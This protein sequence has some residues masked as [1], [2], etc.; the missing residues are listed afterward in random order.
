MRSFVLQPWTTVRGTAGSPGVTSVTQDESDYLDLSEYADA[1]FWVDIAGLTQPAGGV[2]TLNLESSPSRDESSFQPIAPAITLALP[3]AAGAVAPTLVKTIRTPSTVALSRWTRWRINV[4]GATGQAWDATFRIRGSAG[5]S[6]FFVPTQI[7]N[8]LL[9]LRSDIGITT[10]PGN[11][12][13]SGWADQSGN[14]NHA[15]QSTAANQP[16]YAA[17]QM[18]GLP[19]LRGDGAAYYMKTSAFTLGAQATLITVVQPSAALG[20]SVRLL[21]QDYSQT[22][23]LGADVV[24]SPTKYKLIVNNG[25]LAATTVSEPSTTNHIVTGLYAPTTGRVYA[26]GTLGGSDTFTAPSNLSQALYL[27]AAAAGGFLFTGYMAEVIAYNRALTAA[28]LT[29][30]HRYLGGRY[31]VP[32]P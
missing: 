1:A 15:A 3:S 7:Q 8:C 5:R 26:N 22:Y 13:V 27:M 16:A 20:N 10:N 18:N 30:V 4:P 19:A 32:V 25:T 28:E 23:Y 2:V 12:R 6:S 17:S 24:A 29:Q 9:W 14:S 11:G 31:G 21:E